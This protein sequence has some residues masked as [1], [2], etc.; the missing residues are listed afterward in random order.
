M[1]PA[2]AIFPTIFAKKMSIKVGES[3]W[4]FLVLHSISRETF[5][6][7]I[8]GY[9]HRDAV[10]E[11]AGIASTVATLFTSHSTFRCSRWV[12]FPGFTAAT[13]QQRI[14]DNTIEP[15]LLVMG[16]TTSR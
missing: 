11:H 9:D 7:I 10:T 13:M 1:S 6:G 12:V 4:H 14:S 15:E 16:T 2:T 8:I 3:H 5:C